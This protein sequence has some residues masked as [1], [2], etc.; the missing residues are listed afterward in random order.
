MEELLKVT[1]SR[2]PVHCK[3]GDISETVQDKDFAIHTAY[4][5]EIWPMNNDNS[6]DLNCPSRSFT[7]CVF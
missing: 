2:V 6:N 5:N 4:I 7:N 1:G 3:S